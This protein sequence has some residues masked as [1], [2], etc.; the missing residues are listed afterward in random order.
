MA[1]QWTPELSV[2]VTEI[3]D[4]HKELIKRLNALGDAMMKGMGKDEIGR[5]LDFLGT[6]VVSHFGT[7]ERHMA[8][9]NYPSLADHKAQHAALIADFT[10][11]RSQFND[12]GANLSLVLGLNAKLVDWLKTHICGTDKQLGAYLKTKM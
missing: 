7:E 1:M 10:K 11:F 8:R 5:L 3:D 12:A 2:G 6:Y 4:Q 9:T